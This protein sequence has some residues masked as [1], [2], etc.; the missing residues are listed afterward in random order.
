MWCEVVYTRLLNLE[1]LEIRRQ[2]PLWTSEDYL[3]VYNI[4]ND[5]RITGFKLWKEALPYVFFTIPVELVDKKAS[6][7]GRE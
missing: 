7:P 2:K 3:N 6:N 4:L 5:V 1:Y